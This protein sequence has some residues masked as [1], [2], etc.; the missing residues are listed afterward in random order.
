M[1]GCVGDFMC[2]SYII[3][4]KIQYKMLIQVLKLR[5]FVLSYTHY[6]HDDIGVLITHLIQV[7]F[8]NVQSLNLF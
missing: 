8:V 7:L 3:V 4:Y 6:R 2:V 1:S 5:L